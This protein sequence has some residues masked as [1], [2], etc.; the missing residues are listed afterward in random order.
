MGSL[1]NL[2]IS[3]SYQS[4]IHIGTNNTA[5]ATLIGLQDGL[6]NNIGVSVNTNGDLFL[7]GSLTASLQNGYIYVGGADGKTK[8]FATSSLVATVDTGSLVTTASFNSYTQSTNIRLNNL[9]STS[10]SVNVSI[11]NLNLTTSSFATSISNLNSATQSLQSQLATIGGQSGSWI[12]ESETGSFARYDVSNPWS[13]NQTFTN[14]TAT[15][16]S[17][18][19]LTTLYETASVIY[20]S[21]SNQLGDELTDIQTLS[22]SVKIQGGLT[23]NGLDVTGSLNNL[24]SATASLQGQLNNIGSQS[25]SWI[26]ESETGSFVTTSSFNSYTSSTNV[27]LNNIEATTASLL[28]ETN[29][30]ELFSASAL[31]SIN[32]LNSTTQSLQ[33]QLTTIGGLTGSYATTGSNS[34]LGN[35]TVTGSLILSSS[36]AIELTV[37]GNSEFT[38]SESISGSLSLIGPMVLSDRTN[39]NASSMVTRSGSVI[40]VGA[41]FTSGSAN[42]AHISSSANQINFFMK[43]SDATADTIISGSGNI[44]LNPVAPT[45]GFKRY[46]TGGNISI[47]GQGAAI[48][49]ISGSMAWSPI[50]ANNVF[51]NSA[52][53]I[54]YRGPISS[55]SSTLNNNIFAGGTLNLGTAAATNFEKTNNGINVSATIIN[56]TINTTAYKTNLSGS[57]NISNSSIGGTLNLNQ[58]SSSISV[59]GLLNQGSTTIN[60]LYFN[61]A[62]GTNNALTIQRNAIFGTTTNIYASGSNTAT[63]VARIIEGNI[64]SGIFNSASVNL[65]GDASHLQA[66]AIIGH[67]LNVTGSS[68][69]VNTALTQS[70]GSAFFGR[71]N[72]QLGNKAKTAETIFAVGTGTPTVPKTGFLIDSGSNTF[73]EGTLNVSGSTLLTGSLYIPSGSWIPSATGSSILTW[74]SV[75]GQVSQSPIATLISSS[76]SVGAFNSTVTQSGSAA[77]SQSMTFN[78]TDI[79]NGISIVSNSRITIANSGTYN[80]QFSAQLL[81]PTGADTVYIWL[82]KNGTNVS[83]TGTKLVL[84]NNEATVAAWNFVVPANAADYFELCWQNVG[85]HTQL[86]TEVASGNI[87]AIPSVIITVTQVE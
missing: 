75:T 32:N 77:V 59:A 48:P 20:S 8:A 79:A 29:N 44:F 2:Y 37:I 41:G 35:Q 61:S 18:T 62:A 26:T 80:I 55:S 45:A 42:L 19:Y 50:I 7:S 74:N 82:K 67:G 25:G 47:G 31:I 64:F 66:T 87:P 84:A 36:N 69:R 46:M 85:G 53:P 3:Q 33:S 34:F 56:G 76:F 5:S 83:N 60:N 52:T 28:I 38:G 49:Q 30:L 13:A 15:S 73:V 22:G 65:N 63:S 54:T 78:N 11:S 9:E 14:I 70:V 39:G 12:T 23:I 81:A 24:N 72:D 6:G 17:F 16:A 51:G 71:H 58:D 1:S 21:G 27:R 68:Q 40:F 10:A 43:N 57:F 86:L 4:L